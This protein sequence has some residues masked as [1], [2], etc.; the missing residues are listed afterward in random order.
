[1]KG[2]DLV[3]SRSKG[4]KPGP[5]LDNIRTNHNCTW[6]SKETLT[7]STLTDIKD[8]K[9]IKIDSEMRGPSTRQV[10]VTTGSS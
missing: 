10:K 3:L 4:V 7:P 9:K 2:S 5:V 1:M 6:Y 8:I